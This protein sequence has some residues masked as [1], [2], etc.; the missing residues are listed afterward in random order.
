MQ[1]VPFQII[2]ATQEAGAGV[3]ATQVVPFQV[4]PLAQAGLVGAMQ[5]V[6]FQTIGATQFVGGVVEAIQDE[7]A[8]SQIIG[9]V[10]LPTV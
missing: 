9:A 5:A 2:G 8:A 1:V 3:E 7:V 10:Q 6:P 4:K